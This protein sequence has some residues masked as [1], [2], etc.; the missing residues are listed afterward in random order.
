MGMSKFCKHLG[1]KIKHGKMRRNGK[2]WK[3]PLWFCKE[4]GEPII[5][6]IL[7]LI[8][9]LNRPRK[10]LNG[11]VVPEGL[12]TL[13]KL[14]VLQQNFKWLN[15]PLKRP[16]GRPPSRKTLPKWL[17]EKN[18]REIFYPKDFEDLPKLGDKEIDKAVI[19][20]EP[21]TGKPGSGRMP[22]L[23]YIRIRYWAREIPEVWSSMMKVIFKV[24]KKVPGKGLLLGDAIAFVTILSKVC[25]KLKENEVKAVCACSLV[26]NGFTYKEAS[27]ICGVKYET[28]KNWEGYF[29]NI[30]K[31]A[32]QYPHVFE[33]PYHEGR[34]I[35]YDHGKWII[36]DSIFKDD[37]IP[38][39][40]REWLM[41]A[42][43]LKSKS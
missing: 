33:W 35:I 5:E 34:K 40:A 2:G 26:K 11:K 30:L 6:N 27:K 18:E 28:I 4:C 17:E 14:K 15:T 32:E 22:G 20:F 36:T 12:T 9:Y 43:G 29:K 3:N 42:L 31:K 16:R 38:E 25:L 13:G 37:K 41:K 23:T 8:A 10:I 21:L 24:N 19:P 7:D 39:W 1:P